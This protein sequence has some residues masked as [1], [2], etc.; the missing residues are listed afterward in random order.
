M[1]VKL[2]VRFPVVDLLKKSSNFPCLLLSIIELIPQ[3][4]QSPHNDAE[5][6]L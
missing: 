5:I 6:N 2:Y 4:A 1:S 3:E